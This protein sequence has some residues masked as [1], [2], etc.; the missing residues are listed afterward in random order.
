MQQGV[1]I[2]CPL[3]HSP[4]KP[5]STSRPRTLMRVTTSARV[6]RCL[7]TAARWRWGR[8][9]KPALP[10]ASMAIRRITVLPMQ[11]RCMYIPAVARTGVSRPTSRLRIP[12]RM[13][14]SVTASRCLLTAAPWRS[15]RMV[16]TAP[17]LASMA[18][19]RITVLLTQVRC[20]C[21]PAVAR[22]G[23]SRPTSRHQTLMRPVT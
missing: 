18:I 19:R 13:M 12:M 20:M 1:L 6:L 23:V 4:H 22:I 14:L 9:T 3:P 17:P 2:Q 16:K 21:I 5:F 8:I 15:G 7:R 10:L 11:V